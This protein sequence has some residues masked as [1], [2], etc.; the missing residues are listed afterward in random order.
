MAG[1]ATSLQTFR[2]TINNDFLQLGWLS[3]GPLALM[4][5]WHRAFVLSRE[6]GPSL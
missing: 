3:T 5:E 6:V 4:A 2:D 1:P